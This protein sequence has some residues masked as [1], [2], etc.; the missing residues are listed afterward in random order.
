MVQRYAFFL[1][2]SENIKRF[3]NSLPRSAGGGAAEKDGKTP[4]LKKY[5]G[6][7]SG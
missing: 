7:T 3:F 4:I 5:N 6:M 1:I 2:Y